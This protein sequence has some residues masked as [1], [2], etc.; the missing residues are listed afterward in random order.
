MT[1]LFTCSELAS[2]VQHDVDTLSAQQAHDDAA[3]LIEGYTHR[4]FTA[5]AEVTEIKRISAG[6]IT[7]RQ[8]V[9]DIASVKFV[10]GAS[11]YPTAWTF[12]GVDK[13]WIGAGTEI[14]NL[15]TYDNFF[16]YSTAEVV[17]TTGYAAA[18]ADVKA[19]AL[20]VAARGY[21]NPTG[22]RSETIGAYSYTNAGDGETVASAGLLA[23]ERDVLNRYLVR[24]RTVALGR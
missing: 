10:D 18:P 15:P 23:G 21:S 6:R 13:V 8:P 12:D 16:H 9:T 14:I 20:A 4:S 24:S 11:R 17:Y 7:L 19:V 1:D 3:A 22:I 2:K 5:V